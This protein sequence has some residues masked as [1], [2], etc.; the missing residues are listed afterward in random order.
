MRIAPLLSLLAAVACTPTSD[1]CTEYADYM[2]DCHPEKDCD[3]LQTV[4]ASGSS[5]ADLQETCSA[6]LDEQQEED[7]AETYAQTGE[8]GTSGDD[9]GA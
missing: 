5:D 4:Y 3:E 7:G 6:D 1:P 8:C 9:T 2:C